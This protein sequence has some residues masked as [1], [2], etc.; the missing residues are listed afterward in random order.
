MAKKSEDGSIMWKD[1]TGTYKLGYSQKLMRDQVKWL[2]F[3]FMVKLL[4]LLVMLGLFV[5]FFFVFYRLD[6]IDFFTKLL[7]K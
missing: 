2:K 7:T 1:Q 3:N 4:L 5:M 6:S